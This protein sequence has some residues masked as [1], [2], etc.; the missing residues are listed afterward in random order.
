MKTGIIQR[1]PN[2]NEVRRRGQNN[3][4]RDNLEPQVQELEVSQEKIIYK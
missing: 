1:I 2:R 4:N 3:R